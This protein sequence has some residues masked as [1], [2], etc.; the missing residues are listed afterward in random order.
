[1][2]SDDLNDNEQL[3]VLYETSDEAECVALCSE[4]REANI[5]YRVAQEVVS[6]TIKMGVS[7]R[8]RIGVQFADFDRAKELLGIETTNPP[9]N[10]EDDDEKGCGDPSVELPD[11]TLPSAS[12]DEERSRVSAYLRKWHPEAATV[13]IWQKK[14]R[15]D[16]SSGF[17]L[18][19]TEN[20]I[21]FR[22]VKEGREVRELFVSP[23]DEL[24]AREIVREIEEGVPPQ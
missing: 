9:P 23:E 12:A 20:L 19:L 13:R 14:S 10:A 15:D 16:Y 7:W 11:L 17:E 24:R 3:R 22:F 1:M 6:R 4:L 5:F 2:S 8:Y 18:A 21:H